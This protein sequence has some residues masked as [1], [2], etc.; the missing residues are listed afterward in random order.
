MSTPGPEW[1]ECR[2]GHAPLI[3]SLPHT[4]TEIPGAIEARLVS[5]W[6]ARKDTD[7]HV[8]RLYDF[9]SRLDATI[10]RTRVSRTVIDV[11]RDPSGASLY[12]GRAT[13]ELCPTTTFDGE[14]LYRPGKAPAAEEVLRR[15]AEWFDPYHATLSDQVA[16]LRTTHARVVVFDAHSIRSDVPRLFEGTLPHFNIGTYG[17]RSCDGELPAALAAA[18]GA[19][20]FQHVTDGRFE[21]GYITRHHGSPREGVHAVQ[22]EMAILT[23]LDEPSRPP[24]EANWPPAYEAGRASAAREVLM[25][26]LQACLDF[27]TPPA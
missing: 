16:R 12:P 6:L 23:Y 3:L 20:R 11:N 14:P 15:R 10:L 13:T 9:A 27:A 19:A 7:W 18:V 25:R 8:E 2:Q 21:G 24:D 17:G 5:P 4:G 26:I 1:L 22:L